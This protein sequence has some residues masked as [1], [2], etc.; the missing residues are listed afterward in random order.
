MEHLTESGNC[1][2]VWNVRYSSA[3]YTTESRRG[4]RTLIRQNFLSSFSVQ[5]VLHTFK[6]A[7]SHGVRN[8]FLHS[9]G[10][11]VHGSAAETGDLGRDI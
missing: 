6:L 4:T 9:V 1:S 3:H 11:D 8:S 5:S 7:E 2:G 10:N